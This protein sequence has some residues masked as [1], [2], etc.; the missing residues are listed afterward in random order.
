MLAWV[1][2][3]Y[4]YHK[5]NHLAVC[6][7]CGNEISDQ[8]RE[9]LAA[10]FNESWQ[11]QGRALETAI[12]WCEQS[13]QKLRGWWQSFQT[14]PAIQPN[15]ANHFDKAAKA[16]CS[17]V[18]ATGT[19]IKELQHALEARKR[20]PME[21]HS[22]PNGTTKLLEAE[23]LDNFEDAK[24]GVLEVIEE[25]NY[26]HDKFEER[27]DAAANEII[28]HVLFDE[29]DNYR[30]LELEAF[31]AKE[32]AQKAKKTLEELREKMESLRSATRKHGVAVNEL[33]TLLHD[34]LGHGSIRLRAKDKGYQLV[35]ADGSVAQNLSEGEKTAL[36]F[37]YFLTQFRAEGRDEK[38]L[39]VV[40]DDPVSSLDSNAQNY[41]FGLIKKH[42][43]HVAQVILLTHNLKLM[44][45][46]KRAFF[47]GADFSKEVPTG[48]LYV[49]CRDDGNGG[50]TSSLVRMPIHLSRYD[51]EYHYL[52]SIVHSASEKLSTDHLFLL[53][54]AIRKLLEIFTKFTAPDRPSFAD[55]LLHDSGTIKSLDRAEMVLLERVCQ[56][57][58]HG[59]IDAV[60]SLPEM[61]V[62]HALRAA[63]AAMKYIK[64]RDSKH[65][66]AMIRS[67]KAAEKA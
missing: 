2:E 39:V 26:I 38:K 20:N 23:W 44:H 49:D 29:Q 53:P 65:Y 16:F 67:M 43:N 7:H 12:E 42:T 22:V 9:A 37:C 56:V 58:S 15:L 25:H 50:R 64:L 63:T 3:G 59:D 24:N 11:E 41:A 13:R 31:K 54:N 34:Y 40:I 33:N 10:L 27:K 18:W 57:E 17:V 48:L 1:A 28:A 52:F 30:Q 46:A 5:E 14:P 8:R 32:E 4:N 51:S 47:R 45:M 66:T 19:A 21:S 6:L 35:R 60:S 61:T 62:E 55:A 36:T